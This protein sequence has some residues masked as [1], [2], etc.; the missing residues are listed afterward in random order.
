MCKAGSVYVP[1][2]T[3][4]ID[5]YSR[6]RRKVGLEAL[7]AFKDKGILVIVSI[8]SPPML[9]SGFSRH[10]NSRHGGLLKRLCG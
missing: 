10:E 4:L 5:S 3:S 7:S 6:R 8:S 9:G 1:G 2:V